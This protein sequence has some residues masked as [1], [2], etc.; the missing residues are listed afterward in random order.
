MRT[1]ISLPKIILLL[2]TGLTPLCIQ[3]V[4]AQPNGG[5]DE[6]LQLFED[7]REF[8]SPPLLNGAPDYT[9][10]QFASRYEGF[11]ALRNRL[12][13]IDPGDWPVPQQVD[14]HIVRAEMNGYDFNHRV[15]QPWVRDP[16]YYDSIWTSRSDVPGHEG[17]T[18]HAV[19]ELWTYDF[20]LSGDA[21]QR[22]IAELS[23]IPPLMEQ[24]QKNLTGN[25]RDLWVA[26]I[27]D[28]RAQRTK[29]DRLS[30]NL[31]DT[32]SDELK[33]IIAE[34]QAATDELVAWL[35]EQA[36]SKTGP[37]GVGRDNYSWYQ[38]NVHLV[39]MTWEDEVRLLKRELDRAWS[40]LKLEEQ[41]NKDLPPMVAATNEA[42][43]DAKADEAASRIMRFLEEQEIVTVADYME[44]ALR[45]HLGSFVPVETRNFFM[46]TAHYDPAP[47]FTHFW[48]WFELARMDLEP[49]ESPIRQGSVLYNIFDSRNEGTATGVEE[50]FMHAGLYDDS[51]RSRELVWIMVA[52]RAARG[53]GSLYAHANQMTMEEA[54]QV[55]MDWTPRGWMKTE[56]DLLIF[57]QH[58]Y[59]RQPGYGTSY[60]TGKYLLERTMADYAKLN[61]ERGEE[62]RMRDFFDRLNRIDS[63]PISL[64]RWEMTGL[65]DEIRALTSNE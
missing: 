2:F 39:P 37:S 3:G 36:P 21:E 5:Y 13:R 26:G 51:P 55:H 1:T 23:A 53:L 38:Q 14:W 17:P 27:R 32:A 11:L 52:Q 54:G 60:I 65:D 63:I 49:H 25:A 48:H 9:A 24:A 59:L 34:S 46:I 10:E 7:W 29:L 6:L 61:E 62:F 40:S 64:A 56:P 4:L 43:Y 42:E 19:V 31:A 41:R 57:E 16:A 44:P 12:Y 28:I 8:E 50:M 15:L 30:E 33:S 58:L 47:L 22:L 20:P 18:N 45:E 35:E